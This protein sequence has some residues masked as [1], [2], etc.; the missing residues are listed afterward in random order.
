M[1]DTLKGYLIAGLGLIAAIF[2]AVFA[3]R[4]KKIDALKK[5][6]ETERENVKEVERVIATQKQTKKMEER[7]NEINA[8]MH[9]SSDTDK[10]SR[11]SKFNRD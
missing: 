4:G 2:G 5:D 8:D 9:K 11:L 7:F 3:Y 1:I 6:V 10:R